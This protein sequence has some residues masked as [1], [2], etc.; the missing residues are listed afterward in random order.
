M[1]INN[2]LIFFKQGSF[3]SHFLTP[4]KSF[5]DSEERLNLTDLN[6]PSKKTLLLEI[7]HRTQFKNLFQTLHPRIFKLCFQVTRDHKTAEDITIEVFARLYNELVCKELE[8]WDGSITFEDY[9]HQL[10]I[11]NLIA[12]QQQS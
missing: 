1:T 11:R 10:T 8:D 9:L 3:I 6:F 2:I 4:K 5:D 7:D 12:Y